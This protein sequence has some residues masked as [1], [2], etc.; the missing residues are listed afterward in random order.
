M[1]VYRKQ[2]KEQNP[3][4]QRIHFDPIMQGLFCEPSRELFERMLEFGLCL[5]T[6]RE[7]DALAD[8]GILQWEIRTVSFLYWL[9][10]LCMCW[11]RYEQRNELM[12]QEGIQFFYHHYAFCLTSHV[13]HRVR[14]RAANIYGKLSMADCSLGGRSS[15][16]KKRPHG[17]TDTAA[18]VKQKHDTEIHGLI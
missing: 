12:D 17:D 3:T 1:P 6:D 2:E 13:P 8:S 18:S 15:A 7:M 4:H 16:S 9:G 14:E 5:W 11:A 10:C